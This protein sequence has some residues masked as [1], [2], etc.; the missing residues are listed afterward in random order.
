M[1]P[2]MICILGDILN[3]HPLQLSL[4]GS[5]SVP[6][7]YIQQF[8]HSLKLDDSKDKFKFFVDTKEFTFSVDDIRRIFQLPQ[9]TDNNNVGF[10]AAPSF[11]HMLP[12]IH[13][14]L[15]FSLPM[16]LPS[17]FVSKGLS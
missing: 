11:S 7:I 14:D 1:S 15:G 8:W 17:H 4:A 10:V 6:W 3:N 5:A 9:A 16:H 13:N 2:E 12:F